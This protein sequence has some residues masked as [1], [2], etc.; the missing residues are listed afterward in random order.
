VRR[1]AEDDG[2]TKRMSCSVMIY[3]DLT[4]PAAAP[5]GR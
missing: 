3:T 4:L 5:I 2:I 1:G